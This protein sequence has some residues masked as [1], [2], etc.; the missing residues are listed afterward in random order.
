MKK[1]FQKF[2]SIALAITM[3]TAM[4]PKLTAYADTLNWKDSTDESW[5][6][7]S[8]ANYKIGTAQQLADFAKRVNGGT[9]FTGKTVTL[10][11]DID[12][13]G[14]DW[15]PI[16]IDVDNRFQGTFDGQAH[17]ISNLTIGSPDNPN[18]D[19]LYL[20][21]F[22]YLSQ[23]D[24]A[25]VRQ[26]GIEDADIYSSHADADA[27]GLVGLVGN[28]STESKKLILEK[29]Y[30][31]G[32]IY[33]SGSG[34]CAGGSVGKIYISSNQGQLIVQNSY[35]S[36]DVSAQLYAGGI[37]GYNSPNGSYY[38]SLL[39][40]R[41]KEQTVAGNKVAEADKKLFGFGS[42]PGSDWDKTHCITASEMK[43]DTF[44]SMNPTYSSSLNRYINYDQIGFGLREGKNDGLPILK[45]LLRPLGVGAQFTGD[46][47]YVY[48]VTSVGDQKEVKFT[49]AIAS[50]VLLI[51]SVT[52]YH[53]ETYHVTAVGGNAL[54]GQT[55]LTELTISSGVTAIGDNAFYNCT[56]LESVSIADSV[57]SIG[58][59]A[60]YN[61]GI[62][63]LKLPNG[64][65]GLGN[66]AFYGCK[67]LKSV[68]LP[69]SL[70]T[71]GSSIFRECTALESINIPAGLTAINTEMLT[72]TSIES[73][74]LPENITSVGMYALNSCAKLKSI[75]FLG[76]LQK[77]DQDAFSNDPLLKTIVFKSAVP[78]TTINSGG[79]FFGDT[80]PIY[81]QVPSGSVQAYQS[82][83]SSAHC[84]PY[85]IK[86]GD[87]PL[88][89]CVGETFSA[90]NSGTV[91]SYKVTS[92]SPATVEVAAGSPAYSSSVIIP[93]SVKGSDG[94]T[95]Q[96]TRI[97]SGAFSCCGELTS[98][99]IPSSVDAVGNQA[100]SG[101]AALTELTFEGGVPKTVGTDVFTGDHSV[102]C[103]VP[104][105]GL[106]SY[107]T[108]FSSY[109]SG[110][111][112]SVK[113]GAY[114]DG[115]Q[116]T[117]KNDKGVPIRYQVLSAENKTV[118]VIANS[119]S[120]SGEEMIPTSVIGE[121]RNTYAVTEIGQK[122]FWDCS[123]LTGI[124]MPE[125]ISSID[126]WA[127]ENCSKLTNVSIPK[128]VTQIGKYAFKGCKGLTEIQLPANLDSL[129]VC[130]FMNCT[131]LTN[132][133]IP[134]KIEEIGQQAF[135]GCT[136]L[137]DVS[138]GSGVTSIGDMAFMGCTGLTNVTI[139][140]GVDS[141]GQS[142]FMGSGLKEITFK[143]NVNSIGDGMFYFAPK[144]AKITFEG[145][146]PPETVGNDLLANDTYPIRAIVPTG[147]GTA[148]EVTFSAYT[149]C[150]PVQLK[151]EEKVELAAP[152]G[153]VWDGTTAKWDKVT[154]ATGYTVTLY[155][156]GKAAAPENVSQDTLAYNFKNEIKD[157]GKIYIFKVVAKGSASVSDS[158]ESAAS[159]K[160]QEK[161]SRV[162]VISSFDPLISY[163]KTVAYGTPYEELG[164]PTVLKAIVDNIS[165]QIVNVIE[166]VSSVTFDSNKAGA[167]D[168]TPVLDSGYQIKDSGV[169][170][171]HITVTVS[172][173][174]ESRS[175]DSKTEKGQESS[176]KTEIRVDPA[177][178][179]STVVAV[180]DSIKTLGDT[181]QIF[182]TVPTVKTDTTG[183]N[184]VLDTA[185]KGRVE[186][187]LPK[188]AIVQ[189]LEAK[190]DVDLTLTVPSSVAKETEAN[191]AVDI[192]VNSEIFAAAKAN[193]SDVTIKIKDM[194]TQQLAYTW[195]FKGA[196][197][198]KSVTPATDVN[199][200]MAVRL[201]TEVPQVNMVIPNNT[202]GLVLM[203]D[204]SGTLPS[205]ASVTFSAKEKGFQ[206]GQKLYFYYYNQTTGQIDPQ[207]QEYTVD[208]NGNVTVLI[209]HC[210]NYVLLPHAARTITLDTRS[211]TMSVGD[212]YI[213]GVK[214]TGVSGAKIKAYSSTKGVANVNVL[215]NGNVRAIGKITGIT[216][217]MIDVYDSKNKFLTHASVRLTVKKIVKPNGN[218]SRQFGIF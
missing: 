113:S 21:L 174:Q 19:L 197:L 208:A 183:T 205:T 1:I 186:I 13:A 12:L 37:F 154:G 86:F 172:M 207:N 87:Q 101:C 128:N 33:A 130:S 204:H 142:A 162:G 79:I 196:D 206:P 110:G 90:Q 191:T 14:R 198:V 153:L 31:T 143:G 59:Q 5:Y 48:T 171:P 149:K 41:D 218:S 192:K 168:F 163:K 107:K 134:D 147:C 185:K 193:E 43:T 69:G 52:S 135:D 120:Y 123:N 66:S 150:S 64:L 165:N 182:I 217:V 46:D 140:V 24:G 98:A 78:P 169:K 3:V 22:G 18:S 61:C 56:N 132:V 190:K 68:V 6:S 23:T 131:G 93:G 114:T 209:S 214:L 164:L 92:I 63:S 15:T 124:T 62:K 4:M 129:G 80:C 58:E 138:I 159:A 44:L 10:T 102:V 28:T 122:A 11:A 215:K 39:C 157:D 187:N 97:G 47:G 29:T 34:S 35:A 38:V 121:D 211:C 89:L 119:P 173:K 99:I 95:Y 96:V 202:T 156:D 152:S 189:Q 112:I 85:H 127:F 84:F 158:A 139:P 180:T 83:F 75:T 36:C 175:N 188:D 32:G 151:F 54:Y 176:P 106:E 184:A 55:A 203:F 45:M 9:S 111:Q 105:A 51:P 126:D 170:L 108:V 103:V 146:T 166:W 116:F 8:G 117:V 144:L 88:Q 40:N 200:S 201:T 148:Y 194:D 30:V 155:K 145:T 60:F 53:D 104:A 72:H 74:T 77:I 100:F 91:I 115:F 109:V 199:I 70:T 26:I 16:G 178:N 213:T 216:Y 81:G 137:K 136:G 195:T 141:I 17:V 177:G 2:L 118:E 179:T 210:S 42:I 57:K 7:E 167:Y 82:A 25:A 181:S 125:S 212:S 71:C 67:N 50:G 49:V 94:Y 161:D 133:T 160:Y 27:G 76:N 65:T 73:I 20:G